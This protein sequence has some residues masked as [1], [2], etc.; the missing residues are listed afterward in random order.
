MPKKAVKRLTKAEIAKASAEH[1]ANLRAQFAPGW[2][3]KFKIEVHDRAAA[4]DPDNEYDW[5]SL[6]LGWAV[7]KGFTPDAAIAFATYV[8][9]HTELA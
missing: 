2:L 6:T 1:V 7:A 4:I 8:R 9:Y 3:I 5:Y